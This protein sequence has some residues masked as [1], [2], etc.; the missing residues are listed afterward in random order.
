MQKPTAAAL[1]ARPITTEPNV[2]HYEWAGTTLK[3]LFRST[4]AISETWAL[5]SGPQ[6]PARIAGGGGMTMEELVTTRPDVLTRFERHL[7]GI[8]ELLQR[9]EGL[10]EID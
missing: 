8:L 6:Q 9:G 2:T 4:Q 10:V 1:A 5:F 3:R 7:P